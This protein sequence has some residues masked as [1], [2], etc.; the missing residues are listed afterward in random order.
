[1]TVTSATGVAVSFR[2]VTLEPSS[3]HAPARKTPASSATDSVELSQQAAAEARSTDPAAR[4]ETRLKSFDTDG[5]GV[6][7][8]TEFTTGAIDLLQPAAVSFYHQP[9]SKPERIADVAIRE[10]TLASRSKPIPTV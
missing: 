7:T 2:T 1:M 5:D 8:K 4:A 3:A 10:Y 6:V 9:A